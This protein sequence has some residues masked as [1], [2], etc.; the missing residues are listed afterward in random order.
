MIEAFSVPYGHLEEDAIE[1]DAMLVDE[2]F[3]CENDE[4]YSY[5]MMSALEHY[6]TTEDKAK[7]PDL[8][9]LADVLKEV[10]VLTEYDDLRERAQKLLEICH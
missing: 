9:A 6:L 10:T 2:F 8:K 3:E 7:I 4:Y 1:R 5:R